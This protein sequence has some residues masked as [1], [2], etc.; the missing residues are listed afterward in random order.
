MKSLGTTFN[1]AAR[2]ELVGRQANRHARRLFNNAK[3]EAARQ[4]IREV[5]ED[6]LFR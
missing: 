2:T 1:A 5:V 4:R 3:H 6:Q